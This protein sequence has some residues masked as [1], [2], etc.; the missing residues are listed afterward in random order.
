MLNMENLNYQRFVSP[1]ENNQQPLLSHQP[2]RPPSL[3]QNLHPV[4]CSSVEQ[5]PDQS[6]QGLLVTAGIEHDSTCAW[7]TLNSRRNTNRTPPDANAEVA[8]ES[9][10]LLRT[11]PEA[12]TSAHAPRESNP[13]RANRMYGGASGNTASTGSSLLGVPQGHGSMLQDGGI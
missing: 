7:S 4:T 13:R 3:V 5:N 8:Q 11:L 10:D 6:A 9:V 1:E 12:R 2:P